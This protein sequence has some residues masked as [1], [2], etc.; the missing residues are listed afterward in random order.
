MN[1]EHLFIIMPSCIAVSKAFIY[2][3]E[4]EYK[5]RWLNYLIAMLGGLLGARLGLFVPALQSAMLVVSMLVATGALTIY[6]L[7]RWRFVVWQNGQKSRPLQ[8]NPAW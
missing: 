6:Q 7:L 8:H 1:F 2:F 4:L 3:G 5:G